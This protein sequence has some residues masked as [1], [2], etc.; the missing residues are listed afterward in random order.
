MP[1]NDLAQ[2]MRDFVARTHDV[3]VCT[4][5]VESGLDMPNVNTII[6][7]N[8]QTF[9]LADLYQ[10]RGRVGRA[11]R[12]AYAYLVIPADLSLDGAARHRLKAILDNAA[13]G[14][15]YAIAMKDLEIRG[16]GNLLGPQQSGH[17]AAVGFGLYCKLLQRAV[18]LLKSG[19]LQ[20]LMVEQTPTAEE[21]TPAPRY[22]WRKE[23][24]AWKPAGHGVEL[25]LPFAGNIPEDYVESPALRL[26]LFRRIG[27]ATQVK[28]LRALEDE[29][30]DRFGQLPE[31]VAVMLRTEEVRLHARYR[32][33]D[34]IEIVEGKVVL[35]R[36][37][38]I[39][40]PTRVFPRIKGL[41]PLTALD[42]ILAELQRM[43]S[44]GSAARSGTGA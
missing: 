15:G 32:G 24:P 8:A 38:E 27:Q 9:G 25:H 19:G 39:V 12:Q 2:T 31:S 3:L 20:R 18:Q 6:I 36:R 43:P 17:I 16:A 14:S 11:G 29:L 33:I 28:Q 13:L 4:S 34:F 30:R 40:N 37:G 7:D 22:D 44:H 41:A 42:A 23:L 21:E 1:E 35:R 5:I 10:L 26:D